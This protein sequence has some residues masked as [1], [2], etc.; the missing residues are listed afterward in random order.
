M[1][2]IIN[3][4]V[5]RM[6]REQL[7]GILDIAIKQVPCGI[8]AVEKDGI[9]EMKNEPYEEA[10]KLHEAVDGYKREG[11]KVYYNG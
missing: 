7:D 3:N 8:Y 4:A 11:F 1:K 10:E 2:V 9:C 6:T 5:Y